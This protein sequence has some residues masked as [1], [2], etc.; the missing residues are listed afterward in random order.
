[1]YIFQ[2]KVVLRSWQGRA[3]VSDPGSC[4][5]GRLRRAWRPRGGSPDP[6]RSRTRGLLLEPCDDRQSPFQP[7]AGTAR[8]GPAQH[9]TENLTTVERRWQV[10][11]CHLPTGHALG[12]GVWKGDHG[13]AGRAGHGHAAGWACR[14]PAGRASHGHAAMARPWPAILV[15]DHGHARPYEPNRFAAALAVGAAARLPGPAAQC[16]LRLPW[17]LG[18]ILPAW[19]GLRR[20]VL[21]RTRTR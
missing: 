12:R 10:A 1:M 14:P 13:R 21:G 4:S 20:G 3:G 2:I 17:R 15:N 19:R 11:E 5:G 16:L 6:C 18:G 8:V 9:E 7:K